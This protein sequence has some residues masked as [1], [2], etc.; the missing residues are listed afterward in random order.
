MING[1]HRSTT[2]AAPPLSPCPPLSGVKSRIPFGMSLLLLFPCISWPW[3]L[4]EVPTHNL[5]L[6]WATAQYKRVCIH[7]SAWPTLVTRHES[8]RLITH[9][10]DGVHS[11]ALRSLL[12]A[13]ALSPPSLPDGPLSLERAKPVLA[14]A[15]TNAW[16]SRASSRGNSRR[17]YGPSLSLEDLF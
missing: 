7:A 10:N 4:P 5:K 3:C 6:S 17:V 14:E 16:N 2:L 12:L 9:P 13:A 1:P 15:V 8:S 11:H